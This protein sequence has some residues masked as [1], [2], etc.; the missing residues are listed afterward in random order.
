MHGT[1]LK[2]IDIFVKHKKPEQLSCRQPARLHL[3][4]GDAGAGKRVLR[5]GPG[6]SVAGYPPDR[7]PLHEVGWSLVSRLIRGGRPVPA[8]AVCLLL[9][10]LPDGALGSAGHPRAPGAAGMP[11]KGLPSSCHRGGLMNCSLHAD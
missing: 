9:G 1:A 10:A 11:L 6:G 4:V 2:E 5:E 7:F 8:Q 3:F